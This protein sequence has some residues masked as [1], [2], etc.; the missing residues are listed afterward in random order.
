MESLHENFKVILFSKLITNVVFFCWQLQLEISFSAPNIHSC[1]DENF[2]LLFF[3]PFEFDVKK[4]NCNIFS[5]KKI[6]TTRV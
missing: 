2:K 6:Q 1:S 5:K 4:I 3:R